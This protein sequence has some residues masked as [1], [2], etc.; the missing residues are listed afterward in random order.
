ME[1]KKLGDFIQ[2]RKVYLKNKSAEIPFLLS[3]KFEF[4]Y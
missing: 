1:D 3:D 2:E 4:K